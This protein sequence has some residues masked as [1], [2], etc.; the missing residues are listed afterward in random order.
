MDIETTLHEHEWRLNGH[1]RSLEALEQDHK[2]MRIT[3]D[4]INRN[5]SQ[6]KWL[7]TGALG[8]YLVD[9]AGILGALKV[10]L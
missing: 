10:L 9:K 6:I 5:L 4:G 7:G 8:W 1:D 2:S 3:L